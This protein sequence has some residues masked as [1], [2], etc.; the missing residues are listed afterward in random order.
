MLPNVG[1]RE[2][3]NSQDKFCLFKKNKKKTVHVMSNPS[4]SHSPLVHISAKLRDVL[5]KCLPKEKEDIL[6]C[7]SS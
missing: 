4:K 5:R 2:I 3:V 7:S 1:Y 6:S